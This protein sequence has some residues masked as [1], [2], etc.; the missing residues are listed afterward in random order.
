MQPERNT[1]TNA[2]STKYGPLE[3]F[4]PSIRWI[5]LNV[6]KCNSNY[7]H[8]NHRCDHNV[9]GYNCSYVKLISAIPITNRVEIIAYILLSQHKITV[10]TSSHIAADLC[11]RCTWIPRVCR[12][13]PSWTICVTCYTWIPVKAG[14]HTHVCISAQICI[15][16]VLYPNINYV[17]E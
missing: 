3:Q 4:C 8:C 9:T 7:S 11:L 17:G 13:L 1:V 16:R 14:K 12:L 15:P 5:Q 6:T 2:G 10:V